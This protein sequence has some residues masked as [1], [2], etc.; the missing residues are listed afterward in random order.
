MRIPY[1]VLFAAALLSAMGCASAPPLRVTQPTEETVVPSCADKAVDATFITYNVNIAPGVSRQASPRIPYV[2]EAIKGMSYDAL[3]VQEAY[4]EHAKLAIADASGLDAE[5]VYASDTRGRNESAK[6]R[7]D[8]DDVSGLRE[9]VERRCAGVHPEETTKC[10][11]D[12]CKSSL[13]GLFLFDSECLNCLVASVGKP[14]EGIIETCVNGSGSSRIY[15]GRN[16][17]MLLSPHPMR[18]KVAIE[19]PSSGVNRVALFATVDLPSG[20]SVRVGCTQLS[21]PVASGPTWGD[22]SDWT[23]EQSAQAKLVIAELAKTPP[24]TPL[25]LMGDMQ[26][27]IASPAASQYFDQVWTTFAA[28]KYWSPAMHVQPPMCTTCPGNAVAAA[29]HG[30]LTDHV[31]FRYDRPVGPVPICADTLA[32][33]KRKM[34]GYFG[35]NLTSEPSSHG[36]L[37][38]GASFPDPVPKH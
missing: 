26:F 30:F 6:D 13:V 10:A 18:D 17:M 12:K 27:S 32:M 24:Q 19:L 25:V 37:R 15:E 35:R 21:M 22:F 8:A 34:V 23:A 3:C 5:H 28:A 20:K 16:G 1:P 2:A 11:V 4:S 9:C 31:L 36:A 7:C 33:D 38:V 14:L 29:K